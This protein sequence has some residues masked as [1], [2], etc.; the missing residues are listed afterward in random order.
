[1]NIRINE[2]L[3]TITELLTTPAAV[4]KK[5]VIPNVGFISCASAVNI[6]HVP[7]HDPCV[8]LVLSGRKTLYEGAQAVTAQAGEV[9]TVPAPASFYLR[10][11]PDRHSR[12]Y[13]ALIIP[14]S[15]EQLERVGNMHN[16]DHEWQRQQIRI[17]HFTHDT[18]FL[19]AIQHYLEPNEQPS[20][21]NHRLME[22]LLILINKN[23]QLL[24]YILSQQSWSRRVRSIMATDLTVVW[25]IAGVCA[26]LATTE[27]TLRRRLKNENTGFREILSELRLSFALMQ[28]LQTTLP[29]N[30]IAFD[31]GY[32]SVSHFSSN[33]HKR[34]GLPPRELRAAMNESEQNLTVSEQPCLT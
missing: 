24:S 13:R 20:L 8:I 15:I 33:F 18:E 27:S 2:V 34:F 26:R 16:F 29:I 32:Q 7:F 21:I 19:S 14:F 11:E 17:L 1:M 9:L 10:N 3:T 25:D 12:K 6:R 5:T 30:K 28:L 23:P 22:V 4:D 31:C